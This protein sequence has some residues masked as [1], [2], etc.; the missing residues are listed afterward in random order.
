MLSNLTP[1][2]KEIERR[3]KVSKEKG[4]RYTPQNDPKWILETGIY[5]SSFAF[6]FPK[7][8]FLE[9]QN[10]TWED[11][12]KIFPNYSKAVYGVADN[13]NQ[14]KEYYKEEIEDPKVKYA[15]G[16]T[17]VEQNK[18]NAGK[19]GGWRWHKWGKYIGELN[20]QYEYLDDEEF[21]DDFQYVL[22]F[23]LYKL[24]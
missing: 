17:P 19:G 23:Q 9:L 3:I 14:I 22:V 1:D 12:Y 2:T 10:L 7:E 24:K 18:E 11:E 6:N 20:P 13:V 8:E 5:Q 16:I 15:I 4:F 21:G